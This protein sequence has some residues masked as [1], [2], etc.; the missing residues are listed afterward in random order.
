MVRFNDRSITSF[1]L[2]ILLVASGTADNAEKHRCGYNVL[3][4]EDFRMVWATWWSLLDS[5]E[6][7][8]EVTPATMLTMAVTSRIDEKRLK[9]SLFLFFNVLWLSELD[10]IRAR[11]FL[12][13]AYLGMK[14]ACEQIVVDRTTRY[15]SPLGGDLSRWSKVTLFCLFC[16]FF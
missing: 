8:L 9:K 4:H 12:A 11:N 1:L 7:L 14:E 2:F 13:A 5:V 3:L 16:F 15:F 6:F 10:I